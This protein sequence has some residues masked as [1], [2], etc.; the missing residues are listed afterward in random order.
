MKQGNMEELRREYEAA[1]MSAEQLQ[2][3]KQEISRAKMDKRRKEGWS[4]AV[5]SAAAMVAAFIILPNTSA[6]VAHAMVNIP[7]VGR[8]VEVVTFRN[9][10]YEDERHSA[11]VEVPKLSIE[12]GETENQVKPA[13]EESITLLEPENPGEWI[14]CDP[15][16]I[17]EEI[18]VVSPTGEPIAEN[19]T[20]EKTAEEINTEIE[21]IT[22]QM[23]AEFEENLKYEDGY[24]EILVNSEVIRSGDSYFTLKMICY[25]GAGS[26]V[27]WNYFY[28]IDLESGKRVALKDLFTEGADYIT[29]ISDNIKKQMRQQMEEDENI[30]YWLDDEEMSEWNFEQITEETSFY[31]NADNDIVIAFNE[32]DVAPMYMG[33]VEFVIDKE[34]LADIRE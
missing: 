15:D 6:G 22:A 34:V 28:T 13:V 2:K 20:L 29:P 18:G 19:G 8:I 9:Y 7:V 25:Q 12:D 5:K 16:A 26:G 1:S 27:Q 23:I 24:Q 32:G 11:V 14:S 33:C 30:T 10:H 3:M 4:I 31:V 21:T 17:E